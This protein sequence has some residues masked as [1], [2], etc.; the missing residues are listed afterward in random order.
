MA[1]RRSVVVH[2][3]GQRYVVRSDADETYVRTLAGYVDERI[4]EVRSSSK[5]IPTQK[6]AILAALNVADDL[7]KER[8]KRAQLK[9]RVREKS[10]VVLALWV[11]QWVLEKRKS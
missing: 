6:L 1:D 11:L 2:I 3:A 10:K 8:R 9:S 4:N 7:F 5:L